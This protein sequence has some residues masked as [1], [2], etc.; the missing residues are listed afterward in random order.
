[1]ILESFINDTAM[2]KFINDEYKKIE[3]LL[4]R[5]T[6]TNFDIALSVN[7][8]IDLAIDNLVLLKIKNKM[9]HHNITIANELNS[10]F[11]K[12]E[13]RVK[14]IELLLYEISSFL[15]VNKINHIFTKAFQHYPDMGHDIDLLIPDLKGQQLLKE[16]FSLIE[17]E[18]SLLNHLSEKSAYLINK[19][20]PIEMHRKIGH[21]GE[22]N[23]L[24]GIFFENIII[25][26]DLPI[27]SRENQLILQVIQRFYGHM[28]IRL[29]DI[30]LM[31]DLINQ[32]LDE[33]YIKEIAE[34]NNLLEPFSMLLN[35]LEEYFPNQITNHNLYD[36]A[37][38]SSK[39]LTLNHDI[40]Y[41]I[42]KKLVVSLYLKKIKHDF[43][44]CNWQSLKKLVF[45]PI[46]FIY[47]EARNFLKRF[48]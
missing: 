29:S 40:T 37:I 46:L 24:T 3:D 28:S 39:R 18:T 33:V 25:H 4:I 45:I 35:F 48:K 2:N 34:E 16:K 19:N 43:F 36:I 12:E 13:S 38:G 17:D 15:K 22:Y 44:Y 23:D 32:K 6:F 47:I 21:F 26:N 10:V 5:D 14:S 31:I 20:I 1:M 8:F 7:S 41:R 11:S 30:I 42:S 9:N 27:L